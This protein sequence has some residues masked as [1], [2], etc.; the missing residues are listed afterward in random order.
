MQ[1]CGFPI[2]S[3]SFVAGGSNYAVFFSD[4]ALCLASTILRVSAQ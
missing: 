2:A 4:L 1:G 3:S